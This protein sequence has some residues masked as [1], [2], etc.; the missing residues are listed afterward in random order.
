MGK[1]EYNHCIIIHLTM[2]HFFQCNKT[3]I[4]IYIS[5]NH[6]SCPFKFKDYFA[7]RVILCEMNAFLKM[8][9]E[10]DTC[11]QKWHILK[12]TFSHGLY[13]CFYLLELPEFEFLMS[14]ILSALQPALS[15]CNV[16][17][18]VQVGI[19]NNQHEIVII[20]QSV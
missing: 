2:N 5:W 17:L 18:E 15:W 20:S 3:Y 4:D 12:G 10:N 19:K 16:S 7:S 6:F 1:H 9:S 11:M 8:F 14:I 13:W